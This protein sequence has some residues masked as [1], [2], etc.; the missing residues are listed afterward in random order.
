MTLIKN[1]WHVIY[2]KSRH[3]KKIAEYLKCF[4]IEH[5]LPTT[6]TLKVFSSK[7]KYIHLP[8][9]PTYIFVKLKCAKD[10]LT[11]L[12][13]PG[14]LHFIKVG[15]TIAHVDE[16]VI[17]KLKVFV[18]DNFTDFKVSTQQFNPGR[19]LQINKGPFLGFNCEVIHFN[20]RNKILVR[21]DLLNR[22]LLM[23]LPVYYLETN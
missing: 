7:K 8:L 18:S 19:I 23:D 20:G 12:Q 14:V 11:S 5:F 2:T 4:N 21:I 15:S 16:Q 6:K 10:Y 22:N 17:Q 1:G 3:E 13:I 9:F